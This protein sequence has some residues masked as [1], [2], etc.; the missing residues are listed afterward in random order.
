M[1]NE[2]LLARIRKLLALAANGAA[3]GAE[4]PTAARMA[5]ALMSKLGLTEDDVKVTEDA[6]GVH[7]S[8]SA[9]DVATADYIGSASRMTPWERVTGLAAAWA[10]GCQCSIVRGANGT[11][12]LR[13]FGTFSDAAVAL[14]IMRYF[15][16]RRTADIKTHLAARKAAVEAELGRGTYRTGRADS[17]SFSNG[18]AGAVQ[19]AVKRE[20]AE[21]RTDTAQRT[22]T[23][24]TA[25]V[26]VS[27]GDVADAKAVAIRQKMTALGLSTRTKS[28]RSSVSSYSSYSAGREAGS[29]V[30]AGSGAALR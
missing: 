26:V 6:G 20:V 23:G 15:A 4:A 12:I 24:G 5:A 29:R 16:S 30:R 21:R 17:S 10:A 1:V 11:P 19:V 28:V 14:E 22:N 9:E 7:V 18:W 13:F 27:A 25:L 3:Q 2:V 8:Y